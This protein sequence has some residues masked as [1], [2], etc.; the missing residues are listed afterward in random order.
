MTPWLALIMAFVGAWIV[1]N[2]EAR[3]EDK[4]RKERIKSGDKRDLDHAKYTQ[5]RIFLW[6]F[7]V[8]LCVIVD[9]G[10]HRSWWLAVDAAC[11][12]VMMP[13][14]FS[15]VHRFAFNKA[16]GF[17]KFYLSSGNKYDKFL[18]DL[19]YAHRNDDHADHRMLYFGAKEV[20]PFQ[21]YVSAVHRAGK[22][23]TILETIIA[24]APVAVFILTN[25]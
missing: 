8:I 17:H 23:A 6:L 2:M 24:A 12:A 1:G 13:A 15:V 3:E 10:R 11:L 19:F 25:T 16:S 4:E 18:I 22:F 7:W 14:V 9:W 21:P 20:S 5:E